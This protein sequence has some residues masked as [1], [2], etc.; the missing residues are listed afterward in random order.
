MTIQYTFENVE[1]CNYITL[2][3]INMIIDYST[4]NLSKK[5]GKY[6][7]KFKIMYCIICICYW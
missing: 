2:S 1:I 7:F 4:T 5:K 6:Y 3:L